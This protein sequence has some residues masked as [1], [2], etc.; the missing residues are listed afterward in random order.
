MDV[1]P[2]GRMETRTERNFRFCLMAF[3]RTAPVRITVKQQCQGLFVR[4]GGLIPSELA[5]HPLSSIGG[6]LVKIVES[7]RRPFPRSFMRE[8]LFIQAFCLAHVHIIRY[9]PLVAS[10]T[11]SA[12]LPCW[13]CNDDN[14]TIKTHFIASI[15]IYLATLL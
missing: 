5:L 4:C 6:L 7:Y 12:K 15:T 8:T 13:P 14:Y 10:V 1:L 2:C 9:A 11:T 3:G